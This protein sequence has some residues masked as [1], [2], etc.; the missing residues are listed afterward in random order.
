MVV[1]DYFKPIEAIIVKE[2]STDQLPTSEDLRALKST[3]KCLTFTN[4][5]AALRTHFRDYVLQTIFEVAKSEV[6]KALKTADV[7]VERD[8]YEPEPPRLMLCLW[9]DI[10]V[11]ERRRADKV[12]IEAIIQESSGWFEVEKEDYR[13][14]IGYDL[15][16]LEI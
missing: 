7:I 10:A 11:A 4:E 8:Y 2:K 9:A 16:P 14:T 1:S 13:K 5:A 15:L 6:G 12:I 3:P